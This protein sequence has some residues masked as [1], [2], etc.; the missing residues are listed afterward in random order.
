[1][2]TQKKLAEQLCKNE[3]GSMLYLLHESNT[4]KLSRRLDGLEES[5]R[6]LREEVKLRNELMASF[7]DKINVL[8][9]E[10]LDTDSLNAL[11]RRCGVKFDNITSLNATLSN[12]EGIKDLEDLVS[13]TVTNAGSTYAQ[14]FNQALFEQDFLCR[15]F[16]GA[17]R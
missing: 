13:K 12:H 17:E 14:N 5:M 8:V 2:A 6:L 16:V 4:K 11:R 1:M 7:S 15:L 10:K 9:E 3:L